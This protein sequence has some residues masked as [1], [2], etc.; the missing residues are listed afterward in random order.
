MNGCP[1]A[2]AKMEKYNKADT[3]LTEQVYDRML[4]WITNHPN[5]SAYSGEHCCPK[6][7]STKLQARGY[8]ITATRRYMRFQCKVCGSWSQSVASEPGSATIKAVA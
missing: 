1:K 7:E 5:R 8:A 4:P 2:W 6:C 3:R